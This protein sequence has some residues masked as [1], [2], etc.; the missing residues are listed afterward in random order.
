MWYQMRKSRIVRV[1]LKNNPDMWLRRC[2]LATGVSVGSA[3]SIATSVLKLYPYSIKLHHLLKWTEFDKRIKLAERFLEDPI[4]ARFFIPTHEAYFH[5]D[6]NVNNYNF[7]IL[8]QSNPNV[9]VK[10][11]LKL[12]KV[13]VWCRISSNKIIGP[14]FFDSKVNGERYLD[15]LQ[16]FYLPEHKK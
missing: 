11:Q 7:R 13:H 4:I 10:K 5:L 9:V 8:S 14:F 1:L 12:P 6:G 3:H 15:M 2:H 16:Q